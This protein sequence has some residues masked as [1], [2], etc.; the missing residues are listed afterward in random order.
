MASGV[1]KLQR[2]LTYIFPSQLM[3]AHSVSPPTRS[4]YRCLCLCWH[5]HI[6]M[7]CF[8]FWLCFVVCFLFKLHIYS[9]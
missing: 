9:L 5:M 2:F 1:L 4:L 7:L 6:D 3:K 8:V